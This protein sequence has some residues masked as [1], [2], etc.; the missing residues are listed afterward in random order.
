[1]H[2]AH[3]GEFVVEDQVAGP[4]EMGKYRRVSAVAA[5][6]HHGPLGSDKGGELRIE[7]VEERVVAPHHPARRRAAPEAVDRLLG[8][9]R[10]D[11]IVGLF[12]VLIEGGKVRAGLDGAELGIHLL[13]EMGAGGE[14]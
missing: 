8:G 2:D 14:A 12:R 6:K 9:G 10:L 11:E 3:V 7:I 5:R 1:M 13:D 4:E